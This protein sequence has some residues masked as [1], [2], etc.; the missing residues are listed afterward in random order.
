MKDKTAAMIDLD[1]KNIWEHKKTG[2]QL[3]V[4]QIEP[5]QGDQGIVYC[6]YLDAGKV[7]KKRVKV[8]RGKFKDWGNRGMEY[9]GNRRGKLPVVGDLSNYGEFDPRRLFLGAL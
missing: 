1:P 6:A 3:L 9:I 4:L 2:Q 8:P 7:T 5:D